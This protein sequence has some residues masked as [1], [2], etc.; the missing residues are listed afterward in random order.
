MRYYALDMLK[1][2]ITQS[3][4]DFKLAVGKI[5]ENLLAEEKDQRV[6]QYLGLD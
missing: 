5:Y 6:L 4:G 2:H 1:K 3:E